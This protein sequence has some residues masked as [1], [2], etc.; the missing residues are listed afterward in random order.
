MQ[1]IVKESLNYLFEGYCDSGGTGVYSLNEIAEK[2]NIQPHMLGSSLNSEGWIKNPNFG[3]FG[4]SCQIS[5]SGIQQIEPNYFSILISQA[6]GVAGL[7][8]DWVGLIESLPFDPKDY[9]RAHDLGK[10]FEQLNLAEVQYQYNEVYI[11]PS[12]QGMERY[13]RENQGGFFK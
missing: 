12:L 11:K 2:N 1:S 4:F 7:I 3:P 13:H 6:L 9:Q 8:N 5:R 10:V